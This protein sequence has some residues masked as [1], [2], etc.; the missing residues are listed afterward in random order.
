MAQKEVSLPVVGMTCANCALSIERV[1]AKKTEGVVSASVNLAAENVRVVYDTDVVNLEKLAHNVES[2]GYHLVLPSEGEDA[3]TAA[4]KAEERTQ[5]RALWVGIT[6]TVP[7]FLLS[8]GR[9]AGLLGVWSLAPWV[10]LLFLLL[11]TP[12]QFYTGWGYYVGAYKSLRNGSANMDVLV[13]LGSSTAYAYSLAVMVLPG[14]HGHVYFET[15][16]L[17]LTLIKIGKWLEARAKGKT[18]GAIRA[19]MDLAPKVATRVRPDGTTETIPVGMVEEGDRLIVGPGEAFPVDG[20]VVS[21]QSAVDESALTGESIP[22]DKGPGAK[23]FGSTVNQHGALTIIATGVGVDTAMA[24]IVDLVRRAQGTK[25]PVQRVADRVAAV[26]VPAIITIALITFG[27]WYWIGGSFEPALIR[28]VAVLVIACPCALGLATPTAV[29]VGMGLGARNGVLFRDAE[30]VETASGLKTM[31]LD[32][33]GTLTYGRPHVTDIIPLNGVG[34]AELLRMTACAQEPSGHPL[35]KAVVRAAKDRGLVIK[36]PTRHIAKS[37]VGIEAE[38]EGS[39]IDV[40]RPDAFGE[41]HGELASVAERLRAEGKSLMR[42]R[43]NGTDIGLIATA[44]AVKE[45]AAA[46][47]ARLKKLGV[48]SVMVTGDHEA[49]AWA[50]ATSLGIVRVIAGVLPEGKEEVVRK[51]QEGGNRVAMVGDG[52]NDAPALARADIG[53]AMGSGTDV[54]METSD[55]T[56]VG[57]ELEGLPRSIVLSRRMMRGIHENLFWAFFYNVALIP[58][59][60]GVLASVVWAPEIL[61]HLHPA[62]AAGAMAFSSVSVV[63]NSLRLGKAKLD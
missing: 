31:L 17:I 62:L 46:V 22:V 2:A 34:E 3:E 59:A 9:D 23:V 7:L 49:A 14:L 15:S 47:V 21:G 45:D 43:R 36:P 10:N 1:L 4:R 51:E 50:V 6:F 60:A 55:I 40:G 63:L 41:M 56:L 16:A 27:I 53:I 12:V 30:A 5:Q 29:M 42:V 28:L 13:A 25:A 57:G 33:T 26:F 48:E 20:E 35:A 19:L 11:A 8:M 52:I 39:N 32:K 18:S 38:V 54:A 24:R 44:D 37:G 58:V 61:R